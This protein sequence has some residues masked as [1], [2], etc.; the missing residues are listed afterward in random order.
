MQT[1]QVLILKPQWA[2]RIVARK[3]NQG[4]DIDSQSNQ[5]YFKFRKVYGDRV[6]DILKLAKTKYEDLVKCREEG[7]QRVDSKS[8]KGKEL[9]KKHLENKKPLY[10]KNALHIVTSSTNFGVGT[11]VT[12]IRK[13]TGKYICK[14]P[15]GVTRDIVPHI[16]IPAG[17]ENEWHGYVKKFK[18]PKKPNVTITGENVRNT[19]EITTCLSHLGYRLKPYEIIDLK[20]PVVK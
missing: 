17:Y 10:S 16:H 19:E 9:I 4:I 13:D 6:K 14:L 8:D 5:D 18:S 2:E 7:V 20:V 12:D 15:D 1:N 3:E 11:V